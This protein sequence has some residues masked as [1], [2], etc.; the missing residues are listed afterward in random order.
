MKA[1]VYCSYW[2]SHIAAVSHERGGPGLMSPH[3][4]DTCSTYRATPS[5]S[6]ADEDIS[7]HPPSEFPR[8]CIIFI[9]HEHIPG[10]Y[11]GRQLFK[12]PSEMNIYLGVPRSSS[13]D[14][15]LL[16]PIEQPGAVSIYF[17]AH[18]CTC[19]T[20]ISQTSQTLGFTRR[21]CNKGLDDS[22]CQL[23]VEQRNRSIG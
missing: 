19:A 8:F 11:W 22:Q 23:L 1:I 2:I 9:S 20:A 4:P 16:A 14:Q 12:I 13:F 18:V 17:K 5:I 3:Q 15:T 6:E 10:D 7:V 21:L